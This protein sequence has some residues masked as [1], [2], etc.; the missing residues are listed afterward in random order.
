MSLARSKRGGESAESAVLQ[1]R[2]ELRYVTD[3]EA[4]HYDAET[5]TLLTPSESLPFAG[6]CLVERGTVVEIK[7]AMVVYGE[8]QRR[9]RFLI[10]QSQHEALLDEAGVYLFAVC[11]PTPTRSVIAMKIVPATLV[12]EFGFSWV[13]RPTRSDYAQFAWSR[14]FAPSE[15]EGGESQ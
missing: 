10:R 3:S 4:E 8:A 2:S 15:V 1:L 5:A 11:E 14:V 7:S 9:G 12:D 13:S 6:I